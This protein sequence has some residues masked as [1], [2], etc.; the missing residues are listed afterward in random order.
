MVSVSVDEVLGLRDCQERQGNTAMK[1]QASVDVD[2]NTWKE[3]LRTHTRTRYTHRH[4]HAIHTHTSVVEAEGV[5]EGVREAVWLLGAVCVALPVL[6]S[7]L[8]TEKL[9][10][11]VGDTVTDAEQLAVAVSLKDTDSD[12]DC[13]AETVSVVVALTV[14]DAVGEGEGELD[15]VRVTVWEDEDVLVNVALPVPVM[16]GVGDGVPD[17]ED[18][19]VIVS[20]AEKLT[21][22]D[23][24]GL[25]LTCNA[26]VMIFNSRREEMHCQVVSYRGGYGGDKRRRIGNGSRHRCSDAG[27]RGLRLGLCSCAGGG[28]RG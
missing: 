11:W 21:V 24:V 18:D 28:R 4:T 9:T 2:A 25:K 16:V 22:G 13:V 10:L 26:N 8:V 5:C 1:V 14:T 17:T 12:A 27:G 7:V 15:A 20:V 6:V 3:Y 19:V 23:T